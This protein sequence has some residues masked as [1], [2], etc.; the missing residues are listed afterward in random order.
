MYITQL[1]LSDMFALLR[2]KFIVLCLM[3]SVAKEIILRGIKDFPVED[4]R[5]LCWSSSMI[6]SKRLFR[7]K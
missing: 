5:F 1:I 3:I 2:V 7:D 6:S 4:G